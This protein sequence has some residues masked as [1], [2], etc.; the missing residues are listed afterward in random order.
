MADLLGRRTRATGVEVTAIGIIMSSE[1]R[2]WEHFG[3]LQ[4]M[5]WSL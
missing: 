1:R 5:H 3:V 2:F 4:E